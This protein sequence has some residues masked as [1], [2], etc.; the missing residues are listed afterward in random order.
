MYIVKHAGKKLYR[1]FLRSLILLFILGAGFISFKLATSL[2]L[3]PKLEEVE[4]FRPIDDLHTTTRASLDD[5]SKNLIY[6]WDEE[7]G[8]IHSMVLEIFHCGEGKLYYIT[9][10]VSSQ[11]N[12]SD[13]LYRKLALV[14]PVVPQ[15]MKL[16]T[17][18]SY[19]SKNTLYDYGVLVVEELLELKLSYYTVIPRDKY[20]E[21]FI[22]K[23]PEQ[24]GKGYP[25]QV[26]TRDYKKFIGTLTSEELIEG[27]IDALY[28]IATSNLALVDKRKYIENYGKLKLDDVT[29]E[30]LK[31]ENR[32]SGYYIETGV[33][34]L[35]I[36]GYTKVV[37]G[38]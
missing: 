31:G 27:Y 29:F 37:A 38:N 20:E 26:F 9:I 15:V 10:P 14:N 2:L 28:D 18:S 5:V 6:S 34:A 19:F 33:A 17:L 36:A 35:Q 1:T 4:V 25:K 13:A 21:M 7:E 8:E 12:L 11:V 30:L 32:N 16:S 23:M 3:P 24:D 22:S